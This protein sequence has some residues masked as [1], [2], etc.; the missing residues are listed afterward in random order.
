MKSSPIRLLA[1]DVDGTLLDSS[2]QLRPDVRDAVCRAAASG[3]GLALA[4]ARGPT[5]K[6]L[7][8]PIYSLAGFIGGLRG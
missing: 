6:R 8:I 5:S 4:T 2:H 7:T 3:L 1:I